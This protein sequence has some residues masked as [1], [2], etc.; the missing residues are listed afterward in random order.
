[1]TRMA[2]IAML[3][4][5]AALN[6]VLVPIALRSPAP[7]GATGNARPPS[8]TVTSSPQLPP[9]RPGAVTAPATDPRAPAPVEFPLDVDPK[10]IAMRATPGSCGADRARLERSTDGGRTWRALNTPAWTILRLRLVSSQTA[11]FVGT[12]RAC[13]THLYRTVDGGHRWRVSPRTRGTWHRLADRRLHSLHAPNGLVD[14][15]C[16]GDARILEVAGV[17]LWTAALLC[18]DGSVH[19]TSDGGESWRAGSALRGGRALAFPSPESG[20]A[21]VVDGAGCSGLQIRRSTDGG[22]RWTPVGCV[23]NAPDRSAIALALADSAHGVLVVGATTFSTSDGARTWRQLGPP[24][25]PRVRS[26]Q[27]RST[28]GPRHRLRVSNTYEPARSTRR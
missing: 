23:Q 26:V 16:R 2:T 5:L 13:R 12:D 18:S 22:L 10:G 7:E 4:A 15:P 6:A 20:Y 19:R 8:P 9:P 17:T 24:G 11:W 3:T 27:R 14:S 21:V 25:A 1:M 28:F